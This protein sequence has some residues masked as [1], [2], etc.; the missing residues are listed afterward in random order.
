MIE[1]RSRAIFASIETETK[2][3]EALLDKIKS[4]LTQQY[5]PKH[6]RSRERDSGKVIN[7]SRSF[8]NSPKKANTERVN[9]P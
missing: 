9:L 5:A 1:S 3:T 2:S 4:I 7:V 6:P 8:N